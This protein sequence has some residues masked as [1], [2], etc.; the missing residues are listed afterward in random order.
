[1]ISGD[2]IN[3]LVGR[4]RSRYLSNMGQLHISQQLQTFVH[5]RK[6]RLVIHPDR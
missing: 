6:S 5:I 4:P 2:L 3:L 1:L